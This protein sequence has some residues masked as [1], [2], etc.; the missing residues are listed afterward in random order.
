MYVS[1]N[2]STTR[3][4][5]SA[6]AEAALG[7]QG[8]VPAGLERVA[9]PAGQLGHDLLADVVPGA[10]VLLARVAQSDDQPVERGL[11][12]HSDAASSPAAAPSASPGGLLALRL[13]RALLGLLG[14]DLGIGGFELGDLGA[15]RQDGHDGA[16]RVA[17]RRDAGR[18]RDVG[19]PDDAVHL[20][21]TDVDDELVGDAPWCRGDL[22]RVDS[23]VDQTSAVGDR[24]GL[25]LEP[26]WHRH[27]D[28][29]VQVDLDEVDVRDVALDRVPLQVLDDGG[30]HGAVD[31]EVEHGVRTGRAREGEAQVPAPDGHRERGHAVA[32]EH[33]RDDVVVAHAAGGRAP[34][35]A[36]SVGDEHGGSHG[37]ETFV[38][39]EA[40]RRADG[41]KTSARCYRRAPMLPPAVASL[42]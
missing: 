39:R 41:P 5:I 27:R 6:D 9:T 23:R 30:V 36:A 28:L 10:G 32:V 11:A 16:V 17:G 3:S 22:D 4:A 12:P 25:T 33:G 7:D 1:G 15:D 13:A 29:L 20:H 2:A 37:S 38:E 18:H 21:R 26:Q 14:G 8:V 31:G 34:G 42:P 40:D 35:R 24:H 19:Q